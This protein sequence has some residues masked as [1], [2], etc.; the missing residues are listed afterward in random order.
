MGRLDGRVCEAKGLPAIQCVFVVLSLESGRHVTPCVSPSVNGSQRWEEVFSFPV[1]DE[2]NAQLRLELWSR[3]MAGDELLGANTFPVA[4]WSRGVIRDRWYTVNR[5]GDTTDIRLRLCPLDFG[6]LPT[7]EES[8]QLKSAYAPQ[9]AVPI[10]QQVGRVTLPPPPPPA[11]SLQIPFPAPIVVGV[12][13]GVPM[14]YPPPGI[15]D[16]RLGTPH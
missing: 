4:G 13:G 14:P 2:L 10:P 9:I 8:A 11:L 3:G 1:H 12:A 16:V 15:M 7:P 5:S 6:S